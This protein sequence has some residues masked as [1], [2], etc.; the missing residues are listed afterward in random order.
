MNKIVYV[1]N[2][3]FAVSPLEA[4]YQS[5][6]NDVNLVITQPD[7]V[8]SRGKTSP[9]AVRAFADDKGLRV[10]TTEDINSEETRAAIDQVDPDYIV[11][12]AYGQMIG[13]EIRDKYQ[14]RVLNVHASILPKYRGASPIHHALLEGDKEIG[15]TIMLIDEGMDQGDI[16]K[17]CTMDAA[18]YNYIQASERL[19]ELGGQCLIEALD[20]FENLYNNR[21]PQ[22]PDEASYTG[23][24]TREMGRIDFEDE[25]QKII[26]KA[27]AFSHWPRIDFLYG[28][29]EIKLIDFDH[30][31]KMNDEEPGQVFRVDETGIY[32]NC[33]DA[34]LIMTEIQFP[35]RQRVLVADYL[36]GNDFEKIKLN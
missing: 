21:I 32:T 28:Q 15:V 23:F 29:E 16:I 20:D 3:L 36:K 26:G 33:K 27:R 2:P 30:C 17:V 35:G 10:H 6:D 18:D 9:S 14:D 34:T 1:G 5:E 7:R 31:E 19:A 24:I 12:V 25:L 13:P 8:R 22:D 11:V 4:L